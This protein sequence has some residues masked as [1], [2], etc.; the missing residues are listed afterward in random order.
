MKA[1][2]PCIECSVNQAIRALEQV[3]HHSEGLTEELKQEVIRKTREELERLALDATT[4]AEVSTIAV[5][6][7]CEL[8]GNADP[9]A[10]EK[11]RYNRLALEMAPSL[12]A[13]IDRSGDPLMTAILLSI[14]G[15]IIDLGIIADID[16]EETVE[17][18]LRMGLAISHYEEFTRQLSRSGTL[19]FLADNAGEIVF[20]K[21]LLRKFRE[22]G[23]DVTF[24]VKG[25]PIAN[26]ACVDDAK[27]VGIDEL[28]RVI[29]IGAD[30]LGIPLDRCSEAFLEEFNKADMVIS[31]GQANFESLD[32][33][34]DRDNLF[35]LLTAKCDMVAQRL[36]VEPRSV[37]LVRCGQI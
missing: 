10:A 5:K 34:R 28:A 11:E 14:A 27:M 6:T 15:N 16:L 35:F 3:N 19:L 18:V 9:Y 36:G 26:D 29:T 20:D 7:A 23:I 17:S 37:V 24:A 32:E 30:R 12:E 21:F 4:P 13:L 8:I 2:E 31:K 22:R 1:K 25:G 33:L